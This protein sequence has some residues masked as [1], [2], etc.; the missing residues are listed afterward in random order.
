MAWVGSSPDAE[1]IVQHAFVSLAGLSR[2]PDNPRAWLYRAAKNRAINAHKSSQRR[3]RR[4]QLVSK[5]AQISSSNSCAAES[6][7]LRT[8]LVQLPEE[9]QQVVVARIWGQLTF[10]EIAKL[11]GSSKASIWRNYNS[12]VDTLRKIYGISCEVTN[13]S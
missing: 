4:Q 1:D 2:R 9:Q 5:P 3:Q 7:E 8:F 13:G 6:S 12:A 10:D 11:Q